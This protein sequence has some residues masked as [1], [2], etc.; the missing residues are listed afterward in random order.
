MSNASFSKHSLHINAGFSC[1]VCHTAHGM[2][3]N[4]SNVLGDRL[5]NF[6]LKVVAENAGSGG[7]Y[8]R[9][10][11]SYNR[12][13]NTCTLTCHN[14]NHNADG[15]VTPAVSAKVPVPGKR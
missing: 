1:S 11:I 5:V 4:S 8:F 12:G 10:P 13:S 15:T 2:E 3:A 9:S 7:G 14:Y 6:D